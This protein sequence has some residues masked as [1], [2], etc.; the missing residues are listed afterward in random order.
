MKW[1]FSGVRA[2]S[3]DPSY[4]DYHDDAESDY[5][6]KPL[7]IGTEA[8][9]VRSHY[10][11]PYFKPRDGIE[12]EQRRRERLNIELCDRVFR[13]SD[14]RD[15]ARNADDADAAIADLM[16]LFEASDS[17][18]KRGV[19]RILFGRIVSRIRDLSRHYI[20]SQSDA[21]LD[22]IE[23]LYTYA[24]VEQRDI[25]NCVRLYDHSIDKDGIIEE[26]FSEIG[27]PH[28]QS[29]EI[30]YAGR[31]AKIGHAMEG[32]HKV[33][34]L[35]ENELYKHPTFPSGTIHEKIEDLAKKAAKLVGIPTMDYQA[36]DPSA[37]DY[38]D[39]FDAARDEVS[40]INQQH[41]SHSLNYKLIDW[42]LDGIYLIHTMQE[43]RDIRKGS[44]EAY[45][46][47]M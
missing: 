14:A 9:L 3:I 42:L 17:S 1:E 32:I 20:E 22:K 47:R 5:A 30:I 26:A 10:L 2:E 31:A 44:I 21:D 39:A 16:K 43:I 25:F 19:G 6:G 40:T 18:Q 34:Y 33:A 46:A 4:R 45:Q 7:T 27:K 41:A 15:V 38:V 13:F 24:M 11:V 36:F 28:K 35:I 12:Q 23:H 29:L 37:A 8:Y